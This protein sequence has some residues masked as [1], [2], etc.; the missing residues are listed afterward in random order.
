MLRSMTIPGGNACL[1]RD[2]GKGPVVVIAIEYVSAILGEINIRPAVTIKISYS[3]PLAVS[4]GANTGFPGNVCKCPVPVVMIK[5][6]SQR[7]IGVVRSRIC[8]C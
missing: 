8:H 4:A 6:V 5:G 3:H 7:R 1:L 2:I